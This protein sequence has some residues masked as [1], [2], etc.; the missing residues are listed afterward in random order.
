MFSSVAARVLWL[1]CPMVAQISSAH[2]VTRATKPIK[3]LTQQMKLEDEAVEESLFPAFRS[4]GVE[5][6]ERIHKFSVRCDQVIKFIKLGAINKLIATQYCHYL[7]QLTRDSSNPEDGEYYSKRCMDLASFLGRA[8][9]ELPIPARNRL[10]CDI[11]N[12]NEENCEAIIGQI[13]SI[14]D[15]FNPKDLVALLE[16]CY[17]FGLWNQAKTLITSDRELK[18]IQLRLIEIFVM[19]VIQGAE[20]LKTLDEFPQEKAKLTADIIDHIY[21]ILSRCAQ[22]RQQFVTKSKGE[23]IQALKDLGLNVVTNP[24]IKMSG[25]CTGCNNNI[26]LF[27]SEHV[28]KINQATQELLRYGAEKGLYLNCSPSDVSRFETFLRELYEVD[29]KPIDIV[30]DGL[31]VA[32]LNSIGVRFIKKQLNEDLSLTKRVRAPEGLSRVLINTIL[33]GDLLSRF[34]KIVVV[35]KYHMTK[36]P[37]LMDFFKKNHIHFYSSYNHSKDDLFQIYAS[38]LNPKTLLLTGDY[39]RDHLTQLEP[40]DRDLLERWIDTRQVWIDNKT[41]KPI[42][43]TPYEKIPSIA[44]DKGCFHIPIIDFNELVEGDNHE[45]PPHLNSKVL[46]W[47]CCSINKEKSIE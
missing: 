44:K 25:R 38:T 27:D 3:N 39:F 15:T 30:I 36:W 29:R 8:E 41:L 22:K 24:T 18:L 40:K 32:Y 6:E 23:F 9:K 45:P 31:N 10:L 19:G 28:A 46:T 33:R 16:A 4:L 11:A 14:L 35:G 34:R 26:P 42:W 13:S 20:K 43:P 7:A 17:K 12:T 37:G 5:T 21:E 2:I 47:I 1:R